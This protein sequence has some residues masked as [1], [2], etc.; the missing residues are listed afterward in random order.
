MPARP[1][2]D[3]EQDNR[4][5]QAFRDQLAAEVERGTLGVV[6][7]PGNEYVYRPGQLFTTDKD[8]RRVVERLA[9]VLDVQR[10]DISVDEV[11]PG[12]LL[13]SYQQVR[14]VPVPD[15]LARLDGSFDNEP[16]PWLQPH[17]VL[18]GHG[19]I[20]GNPGQ[21]PTLPVIRPT[22]PDAA[23]GEAGRGVSVGVCDT[24]IWK[25]AP[26]EQAPWFAGVYQP[27]AAHVDPLVPAGAGGADQ[28]LG[29]QAGHGTFVAGVV[30][31]TA[32]G[33]RVDPERALEPTGLGDEHSLATALASLD[34]DVEVVNLSLG[35]VTRNNMPS[36][37]IWQALQN[38]RRDV[39]VV[40]SAGNAGDRR[41]RWPAA[42]KGVVAVASVRLDGSG[43]PSPDPTSS[44]GPW[45]DACAPGTWVTTFVR[46]QLPDSVG[47]TTFD[48]PFAT[49]TGTSFAAPVV[50]GRIAQVMTEAGVGAREA[51][52]RLLDR[53]RWD[54]SYGVLIT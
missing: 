4:Y 6:D 29:L 46:G 14:D 20:M 37:P 7:E 33:V 43:T 40:A 26:K 31:E 44:H 52:R 15:V 32:P 51:A 25:H 36:L 48:T 10:D 21:A 35:G 1:T 13:L 45:V 23:C 49:W 30:R 11:A 17:H 3:T 8:Q 34:P 5:E 54:P 16:A 42:F 27:E 53:P 41:P 9:R 28:R 18:G 19:R 22:P 39:V 50:A 38:V 12:A 47:G 2:P 24:G